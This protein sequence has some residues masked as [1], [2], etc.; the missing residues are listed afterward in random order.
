MGEKELIY[1]VDVRRALLRNYPEAAHCIDRIRAV[2]VKEVVRANW[3]LHADGSGTCQHCHHH[4]LL[5]WDYDNWMHYCPTCGAE[6]IGAESD[7][8]M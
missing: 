3:T 8:R 4:Q 2:E 1:R 7:G 6:M 5:A